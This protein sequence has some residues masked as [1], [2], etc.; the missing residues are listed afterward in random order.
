MDSN[1][2][3]SVGAPDAD[4]VEFEPVP[5]E[6]NIDQE[7][8]DRRE[9]RGRV[10]WFNPTLGYG[11]VQEEGNREEIFVHHT[12]IQVPGVRRLRGGQRILFDLCTTGRGKLVALN[13]IPIMEKTVRKKRKKKDKKT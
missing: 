5:Q 6:K 11:F 13:V 2:M 8:V 10:R 1:K 4:E 9:A 12:M 7:I 3:G